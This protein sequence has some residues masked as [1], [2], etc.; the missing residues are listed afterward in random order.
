MKLPASSCVQHDAKVEHAAMCHPYASLRL[1]LLLKPI[2]HCTFWMACYCLST[3]EIFERQRYDV[4]VRCRCQKHLQLL[5]HLVSV[6]SEGQ[7]W[8]TCFQAVSSSPENQLRIHIALRESK[9]P[10]RAAFSL[11]ADGK[12]SI[13]PRFMCC[14]EML[15]ADSCLHGLCNLFL[16]LLKVSLLSIP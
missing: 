16:R 13:G 14:A 15:S 5:S 8:T 11:L 12:V 4:S 1:L 2:Y 3:A 9:L 6:L 7:H 10:D